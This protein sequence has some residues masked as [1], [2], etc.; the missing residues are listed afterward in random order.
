MGHLSLSW[1]PCYPGTL[2]A[3]TPPASLQPIAV[4]P[5]DGGGW[6]AG[7]A[8][9]LPTCPPSWACHTWYKPSR[10]QKSACVVLSHLL[11]AQVHL[12]LQLEQASDGVLALSIK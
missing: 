12:G 9:E 2:R 5:S 8:E 11:Q 4:G 6:G 1:A 10:V 7:G 3:E